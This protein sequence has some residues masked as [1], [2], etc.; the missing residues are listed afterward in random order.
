MTSTTPLSGTLVTTYGYDNANRLTGRTSSDGRAYTYTWSARGQLLAESTQGYP[1]RTFTYNAAGQMVRATVFTQTTE[2]AYNGLGA[3][4]AVTVAGHGTT[5]YVLDYAASNQVLAE[6]FLTGTTHYL[7]GHECL[8]EIREG[9]PLYYLHDG[10]GPCPE[11]PSPLAGGGA[12][13]A[14]APTRAARSSAVGYSIP[15]GRC[16]KGP[17]G[18]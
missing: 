8:G 2:F 15:T 10:E 3:R 6:T 18:L 4:V 13:S 1:V 17:K 14:R 5:F 12:V 9:E 11:P 16:S 7:Y